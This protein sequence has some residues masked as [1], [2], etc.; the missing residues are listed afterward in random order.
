M[1]ER[2]EHRYRDHHRPNPNPE[3]GVPQGLPLLFLALLLLLLLT[4]SKAWSS[5]LNLSPLWTLLYNAGS[6]K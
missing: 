5:A 1:I 4:P 2:G 6:L 3:G